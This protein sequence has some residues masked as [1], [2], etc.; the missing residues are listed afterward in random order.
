MMVVSKRR[1]LLAWRVVR[2]FKERH[3][4]P[5]FEEVS[6][7]YRRSSLTCSLHFSIDQETSH[8]EYCRLFRNPQPVFLFHVSLNLLEDRV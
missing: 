7:D 1:R 4:S 5:S 6:L 3:G 2:E 8:V